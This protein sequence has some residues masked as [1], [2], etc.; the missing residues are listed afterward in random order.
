MTLE[1]SAFSNQTVPA[2]FMT[3]N[4]VY[5]NVTVRYRGEWARSWPKKP[6]KILFAKDKPFHGEHTLNLN[7]GWRDPAFVRECLAYHVFSAC[8][9]PAPRSGMVRLSFNG[10]FRGLYVQVQQPDKEFAHNSNLKGAVVYKAVSRSNQSDERELSNDAAYHHGYKKQ[11]HKQEGYEELEQFCHDLAHAPNTLEFFDRRVDLDQYV[12]YLAATALVQ[13]WDGFNKNHYLVYDAQGSHKWFAVP[14]DLDRTFGDHWNG[15]FS[16]ARLEPWLGIRSSP[17]VTGWNRLQDRFFSE[18][19]LRAKL[20]D[21]LTDLLQN[22]F[23]EAKLFP[24]VDQLE[25]QI[26]ADAAMD[27]R[28]WPA[29]VS[30]LHSGIRQLKEFIRQ[31]RSFL[32]SQIPRLRH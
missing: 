10:E 7:S 20:A 3:G 29:P 24:L 8:G 6:I 11:T 4:E 13:N 28:R 19:A 14:W 21:R 32:L 18:P 25:K 23:T 16:E 2:T 15:S 22:E 30:D 26:A 12:S 27:R 1:Q 31:R 9:V 17:G 5:T